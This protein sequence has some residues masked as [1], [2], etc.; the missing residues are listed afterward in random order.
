MVEIG[1]GNGYLYLAFLAQNGKGTARKRSKKIRNFLGTVTN[2]KATE[3]YSNDGITVI[4]AMML[5]FIF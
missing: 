1:N 5:I 2:K 3:Q 4:A